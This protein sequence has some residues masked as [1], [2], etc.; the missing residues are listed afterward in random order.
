MSGEEHKSLDKFEKQISPRIVE[1]DDES[2]HESRS[3]VSALKECTPAVDLNDTTSLLDCNAPVS[4]SSCSAYQWLLRNLHCDVRPESIPNQ[5]A[6]AHGHPAE[7]INVLRPGPY[8][9]ITPEK[10]QELT[11]VKCYAKF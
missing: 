6:S 8:S 11:Q 10:V 2:L 5:I 4:K 7:F 1:F 9:L 3:G